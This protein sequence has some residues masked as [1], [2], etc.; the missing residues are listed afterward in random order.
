MQVSIQNFD[1]GLV[2]SGFGGVYTTINWKYLD[3]LFKVYSGNLYV[4]IYLQI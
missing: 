2:F 4:F 1:A 3:A